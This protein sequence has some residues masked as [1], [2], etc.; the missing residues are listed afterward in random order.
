[1]VLF[2][3]KFDFNPSAAITLGDKD[4]NKYNE[5]LPSNLVV[6]RGSTGYDG[7]LYYKI[8]GDLLAQHTHLD[9]YR[10]QRI[11]Y[12]A[13]AYLL[14]FGNIKLIP[15]SLILINYF[16]IILGVYFLLLI[17]K[18]HGAN[19]YLALLWAFNV[20]YLICIIRDLAEPLLFLFV[21]LAFYFLE[22]RKFLASSLF[23]VLAIF[24]KETILAVILPVLAYFFFKKQFKAAL[25]YFLPIIFYSIWQVG[26]FIRFRSWAFLTTEKSFDWPFFGLVSYVVAVINSIQGGN[27]PL[28]LTILPVIIFIFI[29][30][31][32]VFRNGSEL[33]ICFFIISFHLI[34]FLSAAEK[35]YLEVEAFGRYFSVLYLLYIL[36]LAEKK[37][38]YYGLLLA[39][40]ILM[41]F[42]YL[43][44]IL[45]FQPTY[46]VN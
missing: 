1:V 9:S 33:N 39:L 24:T 27:F 29:I 15:W 45:R 17:L 32:L 26:L 20:G 46:F 41:L 35:M 3:A 42:G 43:L 16:A 13:L 18:N 5:K 37:E 40:S 31:Y 19:L 28:K 8:A 2:L 21:I 22:K 12:P 36:Y 4:I 11:V 25:I 14:A 23:L 6:F 10:Y 34:F 44:L 38:K 7:Q 30:T